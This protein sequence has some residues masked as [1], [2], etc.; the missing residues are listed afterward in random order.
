MRS[1]VGD[2]DKLTDDELLILRSDLRDYRSAVYGRGWEAERGIGNLYQSIASLLEKV[3]PRP[4]RLFDHYIDDLLFRVEC[5][6]EHRAGGEGL[7]IEG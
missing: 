1:D 6:I 7:E 3:G 4:G 5:M 2:L